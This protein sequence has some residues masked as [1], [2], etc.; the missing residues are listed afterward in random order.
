MD[1]NAQCFRPSAYPEQ[2]GCTS[3]GFSFS[4]PNGPPLRQMFDNSKRSFRSATPKEGPYGYQ[5]YEIGPENARLEIY[6]KETAENGFIMLQRNVGSDPKSAVWSDVF[7]LDDSNFAHF[8]FRP[9]Q[10]KD[11]G[12]IQSKMKRLMASFPVRGTGK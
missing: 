12:D 10:L 4:G 5:Y 3:I 6:T 2:V 9:E 7:P 1:S 11:I 8:F